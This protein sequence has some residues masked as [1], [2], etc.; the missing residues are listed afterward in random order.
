MERSLGAERVGFCLG[1]EVGRF[2]GGKLLKY[3][4]LRPKTSKICKF[5]IGKNKKCNFEAENFEN[6]QIIGQQI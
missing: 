1:F 5:D 2:F 3:A 4:I 6:M